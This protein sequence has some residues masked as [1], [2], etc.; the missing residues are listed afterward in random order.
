MLSLLILNMPK[1]QKPKICLKDS[2]LSVIKN[3]I[4][5]K[6]FRNFYCRINRKKKD[7]LKNGELSCAFF[8]SSILT[9]FGLIEKIHCAVDGAIED[10]KKF[11]WKKIK[12][13]KIGSVILWEAKANGKET[14]KHIGFYVGKK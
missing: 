4:G 3:S 10:L 1:N 8:V 5:T 14:H 7:I 13:L 11:D 6:M 12:K 9:I 2:Y